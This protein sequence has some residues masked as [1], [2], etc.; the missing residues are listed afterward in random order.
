MECD[1]TMNGFPMEFKIDTGA[2]VT[3]VPTEMYLPNRDGA[4]LKPKKLSSGPNQICFSVRG[5]FTA[6]LEKDDLKSEEKI[7][8][9]DGQSKPLVGKPAII[10]LKLLSTLQALSC[11]SWCLL[12]QNQC[13]FFPRKIVVLIKWMFIS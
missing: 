10:S 9:V 5:C 11:L 7:Y 4:L 6:S 12:I 8:V 3:V 2:D 13:S 1:V